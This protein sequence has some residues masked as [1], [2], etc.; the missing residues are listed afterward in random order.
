MTLQEVLTKES[1]TRWVDIGSGGNLDPAF[2]Y[3]DIFPED[4]IDERFRAS[5][6]RLDI[7]S[8]SD[9]ALAKLGSFDLVRMQHTLEHLTFEEGKVALLNCAKLLKPGG[10]MLMTVPDLKIHIQKYSRGNYRE[11]KGFVA[12]ANQRIPTDA[13]DSAYFSIFAHSMTFEPHKWCYDYEGL[14]Y[15]L[16]RTGQFVGIKEL[17]LDDVLAQVPF[18]HNRPEEDVC[19]IARKA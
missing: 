7:V 11:W 6:H 17:K 4:I 16:A 19:V 14:E 9:E 10:Y 18:T 13:P 2:E 12:W 1:K 15:Q 8:A 5:Y 3:V